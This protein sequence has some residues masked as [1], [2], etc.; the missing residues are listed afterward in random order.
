MKI[1]N[2]LC[3]ALTLLS[4]GAQASNSNEATLNTRFV[5]AQMKYSVEQNGNKKA[6]KNFAYQWNVES[7]EL[8]LK[9]GFNWYSYR[10]DWHQC[11]FDLTNA[12]KMYFSFPELPLGCEVVETKG[13]IYPKSELDRKSFVNVKMK[14]ESCESVVDYFY[15]LDVSISFY[16]VPF[17]S[18]NCSLEPTR[19]LRVVI[20]DAADR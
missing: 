16:E 10:A 20:Y 18:E 3:F 11:G 8:S 5:E 6:T 15:L 14:G 13:A 9:L 12:H 4:I 19:V 7:Q 2:I 1:L 17:T